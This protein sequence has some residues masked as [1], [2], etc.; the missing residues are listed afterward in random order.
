M[1]HIE[2]ISIP[3]KRCEEALTVEFQPAP[4]PSQYARYTDGQTNGYATVH[5]DNPTCTLTS[6]SIPA[7]EYE[8][9]SED[10][11]VSWERW[12]AQ[13]RTTAKMGA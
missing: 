2:S 8:R 11:I 5:C 1:A 4:V 9:L 10:E 7:D 12:V 6:A 13:H 3:C